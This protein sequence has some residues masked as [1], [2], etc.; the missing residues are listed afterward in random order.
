MND[1]SAISQ[2]SSAAKTLVNDVP[3]M[4]LPVE[5]RGLLLPGV[6][7]AEIIPYT[8]PDRSDDA[9]EWFIGTITWRKLEVPVISFAALNG[10][11]HKL[12]GR[13]RHVAV[14]NNTGV[15]DNLP[16]IAILIQ[17]IPR[18]VR[19]TRKDVDDDPETPLSPM[20]LL[21]VK[22][23][24]ETVFVPNVGALEKA[25]LDYYSPARN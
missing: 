21:A 12:A 14:L 9:P 25:C 5:D 10:Q 3:S 7:V 15:S 20:E 13:Q 22:L 18:L 2:E 6:A 4:L 19:V 8:Q 23:A 11:T 16:F 24:G 17:G 1:T